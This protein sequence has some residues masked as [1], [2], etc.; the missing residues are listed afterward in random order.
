[1]IDLPTYAD[2][3]NPN[4]L[5]R[6]RIAREVRKRD[7]PF[8]DLVEELRG[9]P[10]SDVARLYE[11][12]DVGDLRGSE[13]PFSEEGHAWVAEAVRRQLRGLPRVAAILAAP[14]A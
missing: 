12:L 2:Y 13:T 4:A 14:R 8:I 1:L 11:P 10:R 3:E 6:E 9:L 7:I 5:W